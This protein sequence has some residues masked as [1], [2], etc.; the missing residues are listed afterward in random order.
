M[1]IYY[2]LLIAIIILILSI[3]TYII[4]GYDEKII[5]SSFENCARYCKLTE[6]CSGFFYN[7]QNNICYPSRDN[8]NYENIDLKNWYFENQKDY[9][10]CN[11]K[12]PIKTINIFNT[13][14]LSA[15]NAT[16]DCLNLDKNDK[17][18]EQVLSQIKDYK[19]N[20]DNPQEVLMMQ[21]F[22]KVYYLDKDNQNNH[23]LIHYDIMPHDWKDNNTK[24]WLELEKYHINEEN[25]KSLN[26]LTPRYD[27]VEL[28]GYISTDNYNNGEFLEDHQCVDNIKFNDCINYCSD[29]EQCKG[30]E[31][32]P[33]HIN[34][35]NGERIL[36][37]N[38]CC[39]KSS[40]GDSVERPLMFSN[41]KFYKKDKIILNNEILKYN[42]II[43]Y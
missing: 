25:K 9:I 36:K 39:P 43:K 40:I 42:H 28:D 16:Y 27:T 19:F 37:Q 6:N 13:H 4:E 7:H 12:A 41:G 21:N 22:N 34:D 30:V 15:L 26:N 24:S 8:T 3:N 23:T 11:K 2:L 33:Y 18:K 29:N 10:Q 32:I 35:I 1:N 20:T 17:I 31:F 14:S 5:D 38:I